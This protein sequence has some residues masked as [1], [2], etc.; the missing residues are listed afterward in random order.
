M[1]AEAPRADRRGYPPVRPHARGP[2]SHSRRPGAGGLDEVQRTSLD[3]EQRYGPGGVRRWMVLLLIGIVGSVALAPDTDTQ[4]VRFA[5]D[6]AVSA[7]AAAVPP[8]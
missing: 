6:D 3:H 8:P 1:G 2:T 4:A 7:L 5:R